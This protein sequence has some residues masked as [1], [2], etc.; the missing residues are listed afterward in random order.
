MNIEKIHNAGKRMG[1]LIQSILIYSSLTGE[2]ELYT[3]TNLNKIL[4]EVLEDLELSI[5]ENNVRIEKAELPE[6]DAIPFQIRQLFQ[7]LIGNSIKYRK[8]NEDPHIKITAAIVNN[9]AV[10]SIKDNGIG[11]E[12]KDNKK[13]FQLF[14]RLHS[15]RITEGTGIGLALCKK[16]VLGHEGTISASSSP[17]EG[18]EFI[19]QLPVKHS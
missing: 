8:L 5:N 7:N 2:K 9:M 12:M 17:G 1:N 3:Q 4:D 18:A 6:I 15:E 19:I 11:F 16:I 13:V 14:Q 10:I